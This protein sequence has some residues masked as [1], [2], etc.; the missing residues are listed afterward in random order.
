MTE[1]NPK[2]YHAYA[3]RKV[4][5]V[6]GIDPQMPGRDI[7]KVAVIGAGLMGSGIAVCFLRASIPT[8]LVD[9]VRRGARR[10]P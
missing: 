8:I 2:Q 7:K 5:Q 6:P 10:R 3:M 9:T 4:A 1:M